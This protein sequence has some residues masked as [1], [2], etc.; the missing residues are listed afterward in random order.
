MIAAPALRSHERLLERQ[1]A[2][3]LAETNRPGLKSLAVKVANGNVTLRGRVA[4]FYEKQ[5]AIQTCRVLAG[6]ERLTDA[7]EVAVGVG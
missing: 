4:S 3:H 1:I 2:S 5:I 6:I 7:V